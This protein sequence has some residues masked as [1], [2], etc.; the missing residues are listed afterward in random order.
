[1]QV[2]VQLPDEVARQLGNENEVPRRILESVA[3][4][5]YRAGDFTRGQVSEMLGL[6]FAETEA[7]LHRHHAYLHYSLADLEA[8]RATLDRILAN[9]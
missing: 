5:G 1:M 7:F 3:L 4:E 8:D 9:K 2:T 6:S